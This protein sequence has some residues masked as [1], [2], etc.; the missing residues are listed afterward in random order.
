VNNMQTMLSLHERELSDQKRIIIMEF[1]NQIQGM[2]VGSVGEIV[3][4]NE[5][6]IERINATDGTGHI[7][8]GTVEKNGDLFILVSVAELIG[9]VDQAE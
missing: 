6:E 8:Q 3:E 1:A 9:D 4:I 2:L 7:I 5:S